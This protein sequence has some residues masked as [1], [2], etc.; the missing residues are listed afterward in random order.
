MRIVSSCA[1]VLQGNE[2]FLRA[3]FAN[4]EMHGIARR[5]GSLENQH[6]LTC[7]ASL[8]LGRWVFKCFSIFRSTRRNFLR[9]RALSAPYHSRRDSFTLRCE[10]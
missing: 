7:L 6:C 4:V 5:A 8:A 1:G 2:Q 10:Q 3:L 9:A